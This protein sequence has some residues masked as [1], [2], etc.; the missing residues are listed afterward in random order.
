VHEDAQ[1]YMSFS[2]FKQHSVS[3]ISS[4]IYTVIISITACTYLMSLKY[5]SNV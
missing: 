1:H 5:A 4:I 3:E 2:Y